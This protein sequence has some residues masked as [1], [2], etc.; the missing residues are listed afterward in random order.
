MESY[1]VLLLAFISLATFQDNYK[2]FIPYLNDEN[3]VLLFPVI[4][5]NNKETE[6]C[7][8]SGNCNIAYIMNF[9][10]S[11][12]GKGFQIQNRVC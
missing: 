9:C 4:S 11:L 7:K 5:C 10:F 1:Q 8:S 3:N 12:V 2:E 6:Y